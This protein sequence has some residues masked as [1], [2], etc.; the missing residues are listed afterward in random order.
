MDPYVFVRKMKGTPKSAQ[1]AATINVFANHSSPDEEDHLTLYLIHC[2]TLCPLGPLCT[3]INQE[4]ATKYSF[5]QSSFTFMSISAIINFAFV[6]TGFSSAHTS[7]TSIYSQSN[8]KR[9]WNWKMALL[10]GDRIELCIHLIENGTAKR[11][12]MCG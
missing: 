8:S 6:S 3:E 9:I 11:A 4:I 7:H 10:N 2:Q 1:Q 12:F 5:W